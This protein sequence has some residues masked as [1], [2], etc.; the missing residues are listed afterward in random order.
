MST[1][2]SATS[3]AALQTL[4][5]TVTAH[6]RSEGVS[7]AQAGAS[8]IAFDTAPTPGVNALPGPADLLVTAFAACVLKNVARFSVILPFRYQS[9]EI[10]VSAE[11]SAA[12]PRMTSIRYV[13]RITTDEPPKRVDLLHRNIRKYGTIYNTLAAVCDVDGELVAVAA[14]P[15]DPHCQT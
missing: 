3:P 12:P 13:L 1:P 11:R 4:T 7:V 14:A 6:T 5:Y 2:T 8:E 15:E 10:T 9:A